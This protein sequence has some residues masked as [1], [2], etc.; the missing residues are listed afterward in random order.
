MSFYYPKSQVK[1]NLYTNGGELMVEATKLDY[2]G[3]YYEVSTGK[4]YVGKVPNNRSSIL[5]IDFTPTDQQEL[6]IDE[7]GEAIIF[8]PNYDSDDSSLSPNS[9]IINDTYQNLTFTKN[10]TKDRFLP[11][12]HYSI[13]TKEEV[14]VGS[15]FR[16]FAK[17]NNEY[18]Y[19]EISKETYKKFKGEDPT[20]AFELYNCLEVVWMLGPKTFNNRITVIEVQKD[21]KWFGF[22]NYFQG[23]FSSPSNEIV[24]QPITSLPSNISNTNLTSTNMTTTPT[25]SP[26][27]EGGGGY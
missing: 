4:K 16:Y 14:S 12:P 13:P 5:L 27:S 7:L 19:I 25:T 15:Y 8:K 3:Y 6:T 20:V 23:D 21:N 26:S 18:T 24:N 22:V 10:L 11:I 17:R 2:V 1:T 9:L